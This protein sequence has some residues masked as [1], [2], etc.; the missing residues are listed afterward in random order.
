M[1]TIA[2][3]WRLAIISPVGEVVDTIDLADT[4]LANALERAM[5]ADD[6]AD[7]IARAS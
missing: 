3:G 5:L 6:I 1:A 7:V 2:P 4:N